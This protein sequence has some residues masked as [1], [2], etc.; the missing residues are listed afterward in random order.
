MIKE[1][2]LT[3]AQSNEFNLARLGYYVKVR[4]LWNQ[5]KKKNDFKFD[6]VQYEKDKEV[7][8]QVGKK[9]FSCGEKEAIKERDKVVLFYLNKVKNE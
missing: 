4:T 5:A 7:L 3:Q 2:E 8:I 9:I 1:V 6:I